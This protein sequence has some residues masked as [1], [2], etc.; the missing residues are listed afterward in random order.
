VYETCLAWYIAI[1]TTVALLAPRHGKFNVTA[2]GGRIDH[3]FFD[4]RI[5]VPF[6]LLVALNLAALGGAWYRVRIGAGEVDALTINVAWTLHNL[7]ILGATLAAAVERVQRRASPRVA[8][9]LPA[10]I[11]RGDDETLRCTTVDLARGGAQVA[12][13]AP[14]R[15]AEP[16]IGGLHPG[17]AADRG[18]LAPGDAVWLSLF[19]FQDELPLPARVVDADERTAR[20]RFDALSAEEEAHLVRALFSRADAWLGWV[21]EHEEDRP[22]LTLARIA[23]RGLAGAG[24]AVALAFRPRGAAEPV[25]GRRAPRGRRALVPRHVGEGRA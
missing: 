21:A 8:V 22:L 17:R 4:A 20:V 3:P 13:P 5:S 2:K 10:M 23:G 9:R 11:R 24:R 7:V 12:F 18:Q 15:A 25:R 16:F 1:P 19:T 14:V 6:L